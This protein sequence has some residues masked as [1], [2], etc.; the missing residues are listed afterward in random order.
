MG[1]TKSFD[2][3][4]LWNS[5]IPD[6]RMNFS[7]PS[8]VARPGIVS[9]L[10]LGVADGSVSSSFA[11]STAVTI[12]LIVLMASTLG[13]TLNEKNTCIMVDRAL[14]LQSNSGSIHSN[15]AY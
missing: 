14:S 2:T 6:S 4:N 9:L 11:G 1:F 3:S 7:V 5:L 12:V 10:F 13:R 8:G 15:V